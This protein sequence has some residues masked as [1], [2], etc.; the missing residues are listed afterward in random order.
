MHNVLEHPD[1]RTILKE[2]LVSTKKRNF[3][4]ILS[5]YVEAGDSLNSW[6]DIMDMIDEI[7][8]FNTNP[9]LSISENEQKMAFVL[10]QCEQMLAVVHA[11]FMAYLEKH[12]T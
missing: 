11:S 6:D 12:H 2:Y 10:Q 8:N 9:L 4:R 7:D 5:L 3:D 1:C